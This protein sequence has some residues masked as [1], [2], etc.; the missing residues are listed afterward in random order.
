M[1]KVLFSGM[2]G[3]GFEWYDFALY[4]QMAL[5]FSKLFFP[6]DNESAHLL[7]TYGI[8]A[9]GFVARPLG[10][11]LFGWIGD[12]FGRKTSLSIAMFMMA[13]PT[14]C[15][16][17]LP[18]YAHIGIWAPVLLTLIRI[19]QGLS[20]GGVY[21]GSTTFVVEHAPP[22]KRGFISS[23][24]NASLV[25]GFL[26]G[27]LVT[28]LIKLPMSAE[29]FESWGWRV[30][31]LLG[32]GIGFVGFFI[33]SHCHESPVYTQA[34]EDGA[35]SAKPVRELVKHYRISLLRT[36]AIFLAVTVPFYILTVYFLAYTQRGMGRS[37]DD[38]FIINTSNM[39]IMLVTC[40]LGGWLSDSWGRR[41]V[42]LAG[43]G[44]YILLTW[45]IFHLLTPD[46]PF[47]QIML[48]QGLFAAVVGFYIAPLGA[49]FVESFPTRV[50][51]TGIALSYNLCASIFG[52]T[53]P[54]AAA[55][56]VEHTGSI[57]AVAAYII[58]CALVAAVALYSYEDKYKEALC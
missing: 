52:G 4:A 15:I 9:A 37:A 3:N 35:I 16:G 36:I 20:L 13:V 43:A 44:G 17:L 45:P 38:A 51:Y 8:F 19:L 46:L 29:S 5:V 21:S 22:E 12:K 39:A 25:F 42:M 10:G 28:M 54:M 40:L 56:L 11:V 41:K 32:A 7:M 49:L 1:K 6:A 26:L 30:P 24:I 48:A 53:A 57:M 55:W 33:R 2:I 50:R 27:S 31:F 47:A 14:G 58:G 18:T 23:A 34:K